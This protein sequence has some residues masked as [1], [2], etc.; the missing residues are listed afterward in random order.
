MQVASVL[1]IKSL[2]LFAKLQQLIVVLVIELIVLVLELSKEL[3]ART[4]LPWQCLQ[5]ARRLADH[6]IQPALQQARCTLPLRSLYHK[7]LSKSSAE[8]ASPPQALHD[9]IIDTFAE[10]AQKAYRTPEG[11]PAT[12]KTSNDI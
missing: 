12:V 2:I 8:L 6:G 7:S 10:A 11:I 5:E 3:D 1:T 9:R 4:H